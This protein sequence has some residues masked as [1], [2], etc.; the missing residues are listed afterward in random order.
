MRLGVVGHRGYDGLADVLR[1]ITTHVAGLDITLAF[2]D[3]LHELGMLITV[4]GMHGNVLRLQPALA[5]SAA[6]IDQFLAALR[7]TLS[8]VRQG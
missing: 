4:S 6:Q 5:I 1:R 3:G 8:K 7:Q 2:E